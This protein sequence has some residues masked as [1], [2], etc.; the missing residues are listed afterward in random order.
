MSARMSVAQVG[1]KRAA[2]AKAEHSHRATEMLSMNVWHRCCAAAHLHGVNRML[3][4]HL[5]D[6]N[7]GIYRILIAVFIHGV[8]MAL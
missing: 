5:C 7:G 2:A 8:C 4:R 6:I 3:T 1:I